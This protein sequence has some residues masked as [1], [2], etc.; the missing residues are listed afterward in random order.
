ML[1]LCVQRERYIYVNSSSCIGT[2]KKKATEKQI[3]KAVFASAQILLK[4]VNIAT[5]SS[6]LNAEPYSRGAMLKLKSDRKAL[7]K[8][9]AICEKSLSITPI[10]SHTSKSAMF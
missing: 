1:F 3:K 2:E 8:G 4:P 7:G 9:G 6:C 10:P 5:S